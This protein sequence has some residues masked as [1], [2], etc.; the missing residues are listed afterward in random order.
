MS[1]RRCLYNA[2]PGLTFTTTLLNHFT[3]KGANLTLDAGK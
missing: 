2:Q 3:Q 1:R